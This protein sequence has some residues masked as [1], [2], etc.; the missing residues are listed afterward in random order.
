MKKILIL[1][2][3][4]ILALNAMHDEIERVQRPEVIEKAKILLDTINIA[5]DNNVKND[6]LRDLHEKIP[7]TL[8][9]ALKRFWSKDR[10][11]NHAETTIKMISESTESK[12]LIITEHANA[13]HNAQKNLAY[14][15][16]VEEDYGL[17]PC[18]QKIDQFYI[19]E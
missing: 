15:I 5:L 3:F 12:A 17:H 16:A 7:G 14:I 13:L 8:F 10:P 11:T 18:I 1:I 9:P 2:L 19:S 4:P 6:I